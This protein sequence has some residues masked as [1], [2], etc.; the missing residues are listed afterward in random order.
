MA[1]WN[2]IPPERRL[3]ALALL[4]WSDSIEE[5]G[6]MNKGTKVRLIVD[7]P[8]GTFLDENGNSL[9]DEVVNKGAE[10]IYLGPHFDLPQWHMVAF[11]VGNVRR[12]CPLFES[13][14]EEVKP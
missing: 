12:F 3:H 1:S 11:E 9:A 8:M 7:G 13:A 14:F 4:A 6:E 5:D 10:G 2:G